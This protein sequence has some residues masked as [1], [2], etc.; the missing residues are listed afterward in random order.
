MMILV[1]VLGIVVSLYATY[2]SAEL[3]KDESYAPV[4]DINEQVSCSKA[5]KSKESRLFFGI[6]NS[7]LGIF[8]YAAVILVVLFELPL[9]LWILTTPMLLVTL[10]L[11]YVL[12]IR[13][14]NLCLICTCA[15]I[16]NILL[17]YF[18]I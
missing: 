18:S 10:Y 4:C 7:V 6:K 3:K 16:I 8:A 14:R 9:P 12:Y 15:H 13:D 5:L 17:F 11:A 2:I 1:A